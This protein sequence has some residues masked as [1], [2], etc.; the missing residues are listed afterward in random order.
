MTRM[1]NETCI[2]NCGRETPI[3]IPLGIFRR[4]WEGTIKM[5]LRKVGFQDVN[6]IEL[7]CE[8]GG[9]LFV[10]RESKE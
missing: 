1:V 2:Q 4:K 9:E 7:A 3:E 10:Y 5:D 8:D 6:C